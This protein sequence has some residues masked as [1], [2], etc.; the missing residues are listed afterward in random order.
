MRYCQ[1]CYKE[2]SPAD[3]VNYE[4]R[5]YHTACLY[6]LLKLRNPE[7]PVVKHLRKQ[8]VEGGGDK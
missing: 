2:T 7:S 5:Y 4:D 8:L 6:R 1:C 3:R